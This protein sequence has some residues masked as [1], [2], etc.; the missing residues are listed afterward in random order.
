MSDETPN[1]LEGL[2]SEFSLGPSWARAKSDTPS[3]KIHE[4]PEREYK[5]RRDEGRDGD[6]RGGGRR[7]GGGGRGRDGGGNRRDNRNDRGRPERQFEEIAPAE[8]VNV[9]L[10]PEKSAIQLISKEVHQ[11]ARVYSLFD[12]AEIILA[13]RSRSRAVFEINPKKEPFL[14]CKFEDAVFLT[15]TEALAHL[16]RADWR[17]KF[18]EESTVEVDPPKG[19][20]QSVARCGL[21]GELLGRRTIT[22]TRPTSAVST[23][24]VTQ[25]CPSRPTLP[26]SAPNAP[27]RLSTNGWTR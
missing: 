17:H 15:R 4:R 11:V 19:N 22:N 2:L 8:G 24:S 16:L 18:I 5:P 23:A 26:K 10:F 6:R 14:R 9:S 1:P 3:G 7:E 21:S 25:A 20:F 13:E 27:R 12:V